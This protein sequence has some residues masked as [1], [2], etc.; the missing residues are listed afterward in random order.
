MTRRTRLRLLGAAAAIGLAAAPA[1]AQTPMDDPLDARDAK[2][3]DRMEKVV[4]ELRDIVFAAQKTGAPVTVQP[5]DTDARLA[6]LATRLDDIQQSLTKINASIEVTTHELDQAKRDNSQLR[7]QV[8]ALGDR[9]TADEQKL[10]DAA[11][12]AAQAAPPAPAEPPPPADP[13]AAAAAANDAFGKA[14]QMMLSGDYDAAEQAFSDFVT[15]YP[16]TPKT[17]EARYWWGK[18]LA[19]RGDYA[20]AASAFIGAIRG[21]PQTAWAPDAVVELAR[22][23]VQLKKPA[24]ACQALA[25]LPHKYPKA[26][27]A[28]ASRVATVKLQAKCA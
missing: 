25:E 2:R 21:W 22:A 11:Q 7:A 4:R 24:D 26:G 28:V 3:L 9:L 16:D 13:K 12:A 6:D 14:R 17:P 27:P 23:L 19:V 1:F 10:A 8:K 5:A 15:T 20:K 18:T